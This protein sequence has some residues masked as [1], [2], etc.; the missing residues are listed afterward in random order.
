MAEEADDQILSGSLVEETM[1]EL[2]LDDVGNTKQTIQALVVQA[3]AIVEHSVNSSIP[4]ATYLKDPM[5]QRAVITMATQLFYDRTLENG[6]SLG[7]QMLV[8]HLQAEY[9][10][11]GTE[12]G[13]AQNS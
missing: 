3:E 8:V 6:M 13:N 4:L 9:G 5:F 1:N 10:L 7:F 11:E 12:D 2:N